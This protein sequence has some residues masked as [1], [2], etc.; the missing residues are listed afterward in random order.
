MSNT[1]L[2]ESLLDVHPEYKKIWH[3]LLVNSYWSSMAIIHTR[4]LLNYIMS[5]LSKPHVKEVEECL[6]LLTD[7]GYYDK[8]YACE[9]LNGELYVKNGKIAIEKKKEVWSVTPPNSRVVIIFMRNF[10]YS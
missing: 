1:I 5:T 10:L 3:V 9:F 6:R 2:F 7:I 8:Y 4:K